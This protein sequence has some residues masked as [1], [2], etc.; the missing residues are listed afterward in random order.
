MQSNSSIG[1]GLTA[2][3]AKRTDQ[4]FSCLGAG[5][6]P[7]TTF[8]NALLSTTPMGSFGARKLNPQGTRPAPFHAR[9]PARVEKWPEFQPEMAAWMAS[10]PQELLTELVRLR[11]LSPYRR[12]TSCHSPRHGVAF[13]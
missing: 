3:D 12:R 2:R 1:L 5:R 4:Q 13:A 6:I 9:Q 10:L 11:K 8:G 7:Q